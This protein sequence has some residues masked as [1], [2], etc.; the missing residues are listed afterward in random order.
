MELRELQ[1]AYKVAKIKF[2]AAKKDEEALKAKLKVAM[3]EAGEKEYTDSEGY[4]FEYYV[5]TRKSL[6]EEAILKEL[7]QRGLES[8]IKLTEAVD[9]EATLKAV[10]AGELPQSVLADN[11]T[12]KDSPTLKLTAPKKGGK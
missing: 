7:H 6:N 3:A 4:K 1:E 9:E 11:L 2:D 12:V 5:Q 8:C 10:D